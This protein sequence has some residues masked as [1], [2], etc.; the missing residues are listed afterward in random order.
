MAKVWRK[1]QRADAPYAGNVTGTV[2]G[3][4][5]ADVAAKPI[6]FKQAS[7]PTSKNIGDIWYDTDDNNIMYFADSI[8]ANEVTAGEW[9]QVKQEKGAISYDKSDVGLSNVTN[10]TQIQSDGSNAPDILKNDQVS[11]SAAGVLTGAGGG[12]VTPTGIGAVDTDLTNA[13]DTIKNTSISISAAGA[14]SGGGGGTVTASGVGA[15]QTNLGNAPS[16]IVNANTTTT[17]IGIPLVANVRQNTTFRQDGIPTALAVG[18]IWIDTNDS[19]KQYRADSIGAN[20]VTSGEWEAMT[21]QKGAVGLGN[22][23][24]ENPTSLKSTMALNNVDN[25]ST[26]TILG[27]NLTG[28]VTGNVGGVA[29]AT[30]TTGAAAGT[31]AKTVTDDAFSAGNI[32]KVDNA[33]SGLKN[34]GIS[35]SSGGVL[36]GGGGGTV[37]PTGIGAVDTD[38]SNAPNTIKNENTTKSD[39]GLAN[40]ANESPS[41]LKSTMSLNLVT[42]ASASTIQAGT[43]KSNVGLGSVVDQAI[44]MDAGKLKFDGTAQTIDADKVGGDTV[45]EVK[46]AA[47]STAETNIIGGAPGTLNTLDAIAAALNDDASFNS[48]I[49][50][51]I[52]TKDKAPVTISDVT[53]TPSGAVG[54]RGLFGGEM[55]IIRDE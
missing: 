12:T 15:I 9:V 29:V 18:D 4:T 37:T 54:E 31:T 46:A 44:T 53:A 24:N 34:T 20:E 32:L 33:A 38:L 45:T 49:T 28:D 10:H 25:N 36:S 3:T 40:V 55:Y 41:T 47:V 5:A 30:V 52:A 8:G 6:T 11:I 7:V 22:V 42:N 51:E 2:G 48:T 16:T 26:A 21:P 23:S 39:V 43:T 19:N 1:L 35:I 50:T 13:P 14:L 27:G 17:D